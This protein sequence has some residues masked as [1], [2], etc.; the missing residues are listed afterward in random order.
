MAFNFPDGASSGDTH[1]A[2][3]G[4][5]YR[6]N[7]TTWLVDSA[8]TTSTFDSRYLNTNGDNIL[9]G[10]VTDQLPSGVVSGSAQSISHITSADLDMG[11]N[12]VLFGNV[13]STEG[14]LPNAST[15]HGMFAHVHGTGHGYFAHG[16]NWIKLQ[17]YGGLI[18]GSAQVI[19]ALPSGVVSGSTQ[20]TD[21]SGIVSGSVIRTFDGTGI[22]SGSL[23]AGSN[24][25]INQVGNNFEIS[26]S[27]SGGSASVTVSDSAPGSPSEG[28]LWWKS[29][30]GNL[31]IYYDGYWVISTD[32]TTGLPAGVVSGS[33]QITSVITD[34][35]IS[36]SAASSG[37]GSGGSSDFTTLT[38]VPSGLVSGSS[39]LTSSYD[40]RYLN[41][42]GDGVVS[43]SVLRTLDGTGVV[44]G[45]VL[46][47][48]D[49]TG[50]V[51]GSVLR[52]LDGTG[53]VSGSVLRTLD[54]TNVVSSSAQVVT[55]LPDGVFSGSF[56]G[57]GGTTIT[58]GSGNVIISSSASGDVTFNGNRI[59]SQ[60]KLPAFFTSSFN[61]GT[62]G[63]VQDFLNAVFYPNSEPSI[64]T[65]NQTISEWT[66]FPNYGA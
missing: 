33:A 49:G 60:D 39:Q 17:N 54:S 8:N 11:G 40:T 61:P 37:F 63:S 21:G 57:Q 4:T 25:T 62:S 32:I 19:E 12:K 1:T 16:G 3:N 9:S 29:N 51:S 48:L 26:S 66:T 64:T 24:I 28:D 30:D 41:V 50:V 14:D 6:Y 27:A 36:A 38:N 47:T 59:I 34:A 46:R 52:T 42:N 18:S 35:Y 43:G 15:Y 10:S 23:V 5:V 31:Y 56:I 44:S 58:S 65:G 55:L 45:S 22:F 20:I 53:V 2:S 13:Y 7:G